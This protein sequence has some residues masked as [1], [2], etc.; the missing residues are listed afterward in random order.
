[1]FQFMK[2]QDYNQ[3]DADRHHTTNDSEGIEIEAAVTSDDAADGIADG[4]DNVSSTSMRPS[5]YKKSKKNSKYAGAG[6]VK[7]TLGV[8]FFGC[9]IGLA[10][11]FAKATSGNA[12]TELQLAMSKE[13]SASSASKSGK[14]KSCKNEF[15][16]CVRNPVL[17]IFSF[18]TSIIDFDCSTGPFDL[19]DEKEFS[20]DWKK[21]VRNCSGYW[22]NNFYLIQYTIVYIV[23]KLC[24]PGRRVLYAGAGVFA[25]ATRA[26]TA[27]G[28]KK[29]L[30]NV[31]NLINDINL[32][33]IA[34]IAP[35]STSTACGNL[36]GLIEVVVAGEVC[37][38]EIMDNVDMF[39]SNVGVCLIDEI[40]WE[41][42][43][44]DAIAFLGCL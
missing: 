11:A 41:P 29:F 9:F 13:V 14:S 2:V 30:D 42:I 34:N 10:V 19:P 26:L 1:M 27:T 17:G 22:G 43:E 21:Y 12:S 16:V 6:V 38:D 28:F 18:V 31:Q 32:P 37:I 23:N 5:S 15:E 35:T 3:E 36:V 7:T 44:A 33:S 8:I 39:A 40:N 24:E 4:D 25:P 20:K